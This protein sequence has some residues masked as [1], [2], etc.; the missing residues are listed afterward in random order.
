M[1][2]YASAGQA[3]LQVL[4][5]E[6]PTADLGVSSCCNTCEYFACSLKEHWQRHS[7]AVR[8]LRKH[9]RTS[10]LLRLKE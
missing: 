3:C 1:R 9:M 8:S 10:L 6:T 5:P 4:L 2:V 7:K